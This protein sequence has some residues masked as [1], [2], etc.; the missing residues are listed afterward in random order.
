M[1]LER[2]RCVVH[3]VVLRVEPCPSFQQ[4]LRAERLE[5]RDDATEDAIVG[6]CRMHFAECFRRIGQMLKRVHHRDDRAG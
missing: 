1:L 4:K 5:V 2:S 3:V 6:Q